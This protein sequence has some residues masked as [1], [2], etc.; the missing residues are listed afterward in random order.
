M[1]A[2]NLPAAPG[3]ARPS[4]DGAFLGVVLLATALSRL[5]FIAGSYGSDPDAW[6]VAFVARRLWEQGA[7]DVS[8]FPG[9]PLHEIAAAPFVGLGGAT[10]SNIFSLL[11]FLAALTVWHSLVRTHARS[12]RLLTAAFAL[13]P[14]LWL[15]SSTTLDYAGSLFFL[16]VSMHRSLADRPVQAGVAA[17]AMAGFRPSNVLLAVVPLLLLPRTAATPQRRAL[18]LGTAAASAVASFLPVLLRYGATEWVTACLR[19]VGGVAEPASRHAL[20]AAYRGVDSIGPA[21]ALLL[22]AA[23]ASGW[24]GLRRQHAEGD[25]MVAAAGAGLALLL[26][27]FFALPA[28]RG[29]LVPGAPLLL[30]LVDRSRSRVWP[31]T[32]AAA[33]LLHGFV[34]FDMVRHSPEGGVPGLNIRRGMLLDELAKREAAARKRA[35][36]SVADLPDS[37][38]VLVGSGPPLWVENPAMQFEPD[39]FWL[40]FGDPLV[41]DFGDRAVRRIDRA[42]LRFLPVLSRDEAVLLRRRGFTLACTEDVTG[43]VRRAGGIDLDSLHVAVLPLPGR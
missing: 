4:P 1:T 12:P 30:L 24:S 11:L 33:L 29:Y 27:G 25:R 9:Y 19:Q 43:Y 2:A 18:V 42:G 17:G 20:M 40:G 8:R 3:P 6:R 13:T 32:F 16:L 34:N 10:L 31:A 35:Y 36:L 37:T 22:I 23:L 21:A 26:I 5:P 39:P 14:L 38:V 41:E 15:A 28:E 7:Y